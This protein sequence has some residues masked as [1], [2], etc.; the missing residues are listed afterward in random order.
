M[1]CPSVVGRDALLGS[2]HAHV[3][4]L[5]DGIG[6]LVVVVGEPGSGK[7]R[8][9][10]E[11]TSAAGV[12]VLA[13]RCVPAE[14]PVPYRPLTEAFLA[15]YRDRVQPVDASLRGFG[16]SLGLL[17][18]AWRASNDIDGDR[19]HHDASPL[20]L[21]ETV[22]RV[23]R[24]ERAATV[25]V[26]EDIHWA[27]AETLAVLEYL[28]DA[29]R[30]EPVLCVCTSRTDGAATDL[31]TRLV[32]RGS[33]RVVRLTPLDP[34]DVELMVGLCLSTATPPGDLTRFVVEHS[35]GLPF[36]VEELLAGLVATSALRSDSGHWVSAGPFTPTVPASLRSS[37]DR[38]LGALDPTAR[39]VI[40]AAALLG[41]SFAWELL[42]AIAGVDG[43]AAVDALRAAVQHQLIEVDGAGFTFRHALTRDAVLSNLLPPERQELAERAWPAI[44]RA[45]PGLPGSTLELA[46]DLAEAAGVTGAAATHLVESARRA[47]AAG[48]FTTAASTAR[49][50]STLAGE[51]HDVIRLDA[52]ELL[53]GVLGAAGHPAEAIALGRD[54]AARL[55]TTAATNG[56]R[57]DVLIAIARA[58]VASGDLAS[59]AAD[60]A[61]ARRL[62]GDDV[63]VARTARIDATAA[64]IALDSGDLVTA[65]RLARLAVDGADRSGQPAVE[66]DA[67]IVAG[68][69]ARAV[70]L[71]RSEQWFERAVAVA[72][73]AQLGEWHLRAQQ[74]IA[75]S[76]WSL[77][78]QQ[79]LRETRSVAA[80][81][82]AMSTVAVMDL[83]LA[84]IALSNFA[85]AEC[86]DAATSCVEISRRFRLAT[87]SV[88]QLWLAGAHALRGDVAGM[89][90]AIDAALAPDPHDP[91]ILGDLYGRVLATRAFVQDDLA[92]LPMLMS[93]M[94]DHVRRAPPG[95]SVFPGRVLWALLRT[96][97]DDDVGASARV[98]LA[99]STNRFASEYFVRASDVV[100]AVALGRHGDAAGAMARFA[101]AYASLTAIPLTLGTVHASSIL[102]AQAAIRDGWGEPVVWLRAAEAYFAERGFER[103]ARRCRITLGAAGAP[104]PRRGRGNAVVPSGLRRYGVTSREIEVL[105][106]VV[107]GHTNKQ[108]ADTL[109]VSPK[110]VERHLS[111]LFTR[112]AVASRGALAEA[113]A[114]HLVAPER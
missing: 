41:R 98:E 92:Q 75:L 37:I 20:V 66:C 15:A 10:R 70:E 84:D 62:V 12:S 1:L 94:I 5:S 38:R 27:D 32:E 46:A 47:F 40:G 78:N 3:Q 18:P 71:E 65:E 64:H 60:V 83:S 106:L 57:A 93:S 36:L 25:L 109:F 105:Q 67:S 99:A 52:D 33:S 101:P 110:T 77:G 79:L 42:P 113:A 88:A 85:S 30:S 14:S 9:V 35:D 44:E 74:E 112:L 29:V 69:A 86:L 34:A 103:L 95:T 114:P 11:L 56:R 97:D 51:A 45:N 72:R 19:D 21:G 111:S 91:R 39:A 63:D 90:D 24:V 76:V 73:A 8:L 7:T 81:Y 2:L 48:A 55:A 107:T 87:E 23:L 102:I 82:G 50:A 16:P 49:R 80:T 108:I 89:N 96:I 43:R 104:M 6:G 61:D 26:I 53:V 59:A 100:E 68:R 17:V 28:A 13:G 31:I 22:V 58:A 4:A 54:V